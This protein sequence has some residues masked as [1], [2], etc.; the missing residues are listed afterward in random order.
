VG[1]SPAGLTGSDAK[2]R[3]EAQSSELSVSSL[4]LFASLRVSSAVVGSAFCSAPVGS[5]DAFSKWS[6]VVCK[7]C[8]AATA[9]LLPIHEQTT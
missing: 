5:A 4:S 7:Q 6:S 1:S 8:F 3:T 9:W 2:T